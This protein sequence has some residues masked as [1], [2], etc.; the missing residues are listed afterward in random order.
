MPSTDNRSSD[1]P[2][3]RIAISGA[4]GFLGSALAA[5]LQREGL[6]IQRLR[7]GERAASPD[8]AW[9][10]D[11][12]KLDVAALDGVDAVVNLSGE[13]IARRWTAK[14]KRAIHESRVSATTL[15]ARSI[16]ELDHPPKVFVSGSAIG[17]YGNRES[18]ELDEDSTLGSD[19]LAEVAIDWER[20]TEAARA[21][22]VRVVLIRT[23][24]VLN[25]R[26]GAL[27]K[28][29]LPFKLGVGGRIGSGEQWM[30]WIALEDWVAAVE[31]VLAED[32][33]GPVNVVAP[34]P[35]PNADFAKT[36]AR[37]LRRPAVAPV[38]AIAIALVF[39]EMGR[40]TLLSSQR[41][42]PRR[43]DERGFQFAHSTLEQ[44]LRAELGSRALAP[45]PLESSPSTRS[46]R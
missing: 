42:H 6:T 30:S 34:N 3:R 9:H 35:V 5:R 10:P 20:S 12:G 13:Q 2:I 46:A 19:F 18:E 37:V 45:G 44:A 29:L 43:L 15:L 28:M 7:R 36:L 8:I 33:A 11:V 26:G 21:A 32:L 27:K 40:T 23:G 17:I 25:P 1:Y 24:I 22:G 16:A 31:F 4:S 39:G 41:V 14:R 38:P